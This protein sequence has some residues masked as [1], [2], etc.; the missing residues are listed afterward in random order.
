MKLSTG[1][2]KNVFAFDLCI[3]AFVTTL[4]L[5]VQKHVTTSLVVAGS[6]YTSFLL[7]FFLKKMIESGFQWFCLRVYQHQYELRLWAVV[8]DSS[9]CVCVCRIYVIYSQLWKYKT[10]LRWKFNSLLLLPH[11]IIFIFLPFSVLKDKSSV[12][13]HTLYF[14]CRL[15]H[16]SRESSS[17]LLNNHLYNPLLRPIIDV[18]FG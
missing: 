2:D 9:W 10:F 17:I 12:M 1:C 8:C 15:F 5:K 6:S 11:C 13:Y 16:R 18:I 14:W 4:R 7:P 3:K